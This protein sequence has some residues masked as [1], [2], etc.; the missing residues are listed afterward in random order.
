[1]K[2]NEDKVYI[3]IMGFEEICNILVYAFFIWNHLVSA[4]YILNSFL[5]TFQMSLDG[6]MTDTE[7]VD[8]K[9]ICNFAVFYLTLFI[10]SKSS[11]KL[12]H[13]KLEIYDLYTGTL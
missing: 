7:V 4:N 5:W 8:L 10:R 3:K 2:S 12:S 6:Q 1:M 13:L 11:L 9:G